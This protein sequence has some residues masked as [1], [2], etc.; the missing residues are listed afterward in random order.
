MNGLTHQLLATLWAGQP[1]FRE[2]AAR[3]AGECETMSPAEAGVIGRDLMMRREHIGTELFGVAAWLASEGTAGND[4]LIDFTDCIAILPEARYSRIAE[5]PD[6]LI[7]DEVSECFGEFGFISRIEEV[8]DKALVGDEGGLLFYLVFGEGQERMKTPDLWSDTNVAE[9][10]PRLYAK[11]G[12]L[13]R[14]LEQPSVQS[15]PSQSKV[16]LNDFIS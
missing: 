10:F 16:T 12:H 3:L 4:S 6:N 15:D 8:F 14:A 9:Y 2:V 1:S 11:Y 5:N 13:L 7:D